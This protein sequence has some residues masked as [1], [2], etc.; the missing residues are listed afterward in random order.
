MLRIIRPDLL[1]ALVG[2]ALGTAA[3]LLSQDAIAHAPP[4]AAAQTDILDQA[5]PAPMP[6]HARAS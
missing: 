5:P 2:F 3:L 4:P 1:C 6:A